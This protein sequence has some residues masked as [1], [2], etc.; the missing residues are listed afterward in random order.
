MPDHLEG[1]GVI[2]STAYRYLPI[3]VPSHWGVTPASWLA[4]HEPASERLVVLLPGR[5]Y[6]CDYPLFYYIRRMA[7]DNGWDVLSV[8][9]GFQA[10]DADIFRD[11]IPRICDETADAIALAM[12]R[13]YRQ[14]S[15]VGKSL[16]SLFASELVTR[17]PLIPVDRLVLLTPLPGSLSSTVPV[18]TLAVIGT[19]DPIYQDEEVR[20]ALHSSVE[21]RAWEVLEQLNH[22]LEHPG[23]W[24]ESLAV[25]P[26]VVDSCETFMLGEQS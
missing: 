23:G 5:R 9:Y 16:G 19:G 20:R 21:G 10:T 18:R 14:V 3:A 8:Q 15:L 6:T 13:G 26:R 12:E 22:S 24:R 25:I 7:L 4:H 2:M 1:V 11:D 17:H